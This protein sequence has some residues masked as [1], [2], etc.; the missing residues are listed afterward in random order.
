MEKA[1][2]TDD[3]YK[4]VLLSEQKY[5]EVK[6]LAFGIWKSHF[7]TCRATHYETSDSPK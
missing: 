2:K 3:I 4:T 6:I 7:P 5:H 1:M